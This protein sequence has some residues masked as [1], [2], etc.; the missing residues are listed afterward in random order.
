MS[1]TQ[2]EM[3]D[4]PQE[5][6]DKYLGYIDRSIKKFEFYCEQKDYEWVAAALKL[7]RK[8][9]GVSTNTDVILHLLKQIEGLSHA[10]SEVEE[11]A[12]LR[13]SNRKRTK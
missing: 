12:G 4:T 5:K 8:R 13:P 11:K 2:L 9:L 10:D 1:R 7:W 3:Y 6:K